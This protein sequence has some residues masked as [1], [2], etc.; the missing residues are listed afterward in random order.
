MVAKIH[1][2]TWSNGGKGREAFVIA[3]RVQSRFYMV[4]AALYL[5]A[6]MQSSRDGLI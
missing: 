4:P 6:M 3:M 2:K 1:Y 5:S